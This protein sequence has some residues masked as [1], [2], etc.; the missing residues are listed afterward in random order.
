MFITV[1]PVQ[2]KEQVKHGQAG[3]LWP[4]ET[5]GRFDKKGHAGRQG[6]EN[7][8]QVEYWNRLRGHVDMQRRYT[9]TCRLK[10]QADTN[11]YKYFWQTYTVGQE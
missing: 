5:Q 11:A 6:R 7:D 1:W 2:T 10:A 3:M 4:V 8:R 9:R